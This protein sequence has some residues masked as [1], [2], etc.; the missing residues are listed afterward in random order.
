MYDL[1]PCRFDDGIAA[2]ENVDLY[3]CM[4]EQLLC[5]NYTLLITVHHHAAHVRQQLCER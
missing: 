3:Y 5:C 2:G 4:S 1:C